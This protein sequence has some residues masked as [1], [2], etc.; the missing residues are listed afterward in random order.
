[1]LSTDPIVLEAEEFQQTGTKIVS[2]PHLGLPS[3]GQWLRAETSE[4]QVRIPLE[5]IETGFYDVTLRGIGDYLR[6]VLGGHQTIEINAKAYLDNYTFAA[7]YFA[8][9]QTD[10]LVTLPPSAGIDQITLT[11]NQVDYDKLPTLF[12]LEQYLAPTASD[13]D[14][15]ITLL[16]AF[17]VER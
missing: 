14:T 6:V 13:L 15:I 8:G 12:G 2:I 9:G 10:I 4:A 7:L 5:S 3:S 17:G 16:A 1:P 11:R